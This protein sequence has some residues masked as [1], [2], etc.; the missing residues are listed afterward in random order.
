MDR[1]FDTEPV[2]ADEAL[3]RAS[4]RGRHKLARVD[5]AAGLSGE[6]SA[7]IWILVLGLG[8][9]DGWPKFG[10]SGRGDADEG[11]SE[12]ERGIRCAPLQVVS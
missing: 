8:C 10:A 12:D 5:V 6:V 2:A 4:K 1:P 11:R 9:A 7:V 3:E